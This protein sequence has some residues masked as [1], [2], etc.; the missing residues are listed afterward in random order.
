MFFNLMNMKIIHGKDFWSTYNR[1]SYTKT[2][3]P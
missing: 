3:F 2:G 1:N